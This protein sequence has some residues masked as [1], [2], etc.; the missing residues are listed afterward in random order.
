MRQLA[1]LLAG[2]VLAAAALAVSATSSTTGPVRAPGATAS[3]RSAVLLIASAAL[4]PPAPCRGCWKPEVG[5]SWQIQLT[6]RVD[7]SVKARVYVVDL[8]DTPASTVARLHALERRAV[9]YVSAGSLEEWRPDAA[10]FPPGVIGR[11]LLGWSDERWLDIR[12]I[13][14]LAPVMRARLDLCRSK[15]FDAV[16]PDNVDGWLNATG[17]ALT[18]DDEARYVAWLANEAHDRGLAVTLKND[19]PQAARLVGYVDAA[20][21]EQ[22]FAYGECDLARPFV[23]AHKPVWEIEY[24]LSPATFCAKA[25]ALGFDALRKKLDLGAWRVPCGHA[26][27][28]HG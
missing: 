9:C 4:P 10:R 1:A 19:L 27:R 12:R 24:G 3:S 11:P 6:G 18:A 13:D 8:F 21:V 7:L 28:A 5:S 26:K 17:F 22:C 16:D 15:G 25:R 14:L 23:A 2:A 20:V